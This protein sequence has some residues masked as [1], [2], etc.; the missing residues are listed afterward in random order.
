MPEVCYPTGMG[1][2]IMYEGVQFEASDAAEAAELF[3]QLR[4]GP[5]PSIRVNPPQPATA[6]KGPQ[7][8]SV[9]PTEFPDWV[10]PAAL[11]FLVAIREAPS[12]G[13]DSA[14]MMKALGLALDQ[15]KALGGRSAMIN[16]LIEDTGLSPSSVYDN[17]RTGK[18]RFWKPKRYLSEAIANVEKRLAAAK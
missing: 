4:G 8:Q 9:L 6:S 10:A 1:I 16:R 7:Y 14:T 11:K 15:P 5:V 17:K 12:E 18:G 13:A 3:R 2:K